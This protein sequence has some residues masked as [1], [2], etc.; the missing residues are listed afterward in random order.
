[1]LRRKKLNYTL[2]AQRIRSSLFFAKTSL[3]EI[4]LLFVCGDHEMV[5]LRYNRNALYGC[6]KIGYFFF[7]VNLFNLQAK[8]RLL[9]S[10][11]PFFSTSRSIKSPSSRED[12]GNSDDVDKKPL[13][14][15]R[16]NHL[17]EACWEQSRKLA[18]SESCVRFRKII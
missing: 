13:C 10:M 7:G 11:A 1:M 2:K 12:L 16:S 14:L 9:K 6:T 8:M 17:G 4:S 18:E 15:K 5:I 3:I